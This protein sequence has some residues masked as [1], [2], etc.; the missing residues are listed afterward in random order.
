MRVL[1]DHQVFSLQAWGG[2]SRYFT[3]LMKYYE[4]G[5]K[6]QFE[7]PIYFSNNVHL[8]EVVSV[9]AKTFFNDYPFKGRNRIIFQVNQLVTRK[10]WRKKEFELFHPT[11]YNSDFL[12][13][14][15]SRP[16]ILT[17]HDMTY[18]IYPEL[19]PPGDPVPQHKKILIERASRIIA[20]SRHTK[21]DILR[22]YPVSPDKIEVIY[23]GNSLYKDQV[24][25]E[26]DPHLPLKFLLYVGNREGHKNFTRFIRA[27]TPLLQ[28]D[29]DLFLVCAGGG[30]LSKA[31]TTLITELGII[32]KVHHYPVNDLELIRLYSHARAFVFPSLYEGFGIPVLEAFGCNCPA[33]L[34]NSSSLPEIA[35]D[36]ALYFD[37]E[38]ENSI[39]EIV[40]HLIDNENLRK[41]LIE[42]GSERVREFSWKKTALK[43][44]TLYEK[45]LEE[46]N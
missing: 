46:A 42:R 45:V 12:N 2:I 9:S 3:E 7:L 38:D 11:Y 17:I 26:S 40:S 4:R 33:I 10:I 30:S 8:P 35:G 6:L 32:N 23:L 43:T 18:E 31:E 20:I 21:S 37:P 36:A 15:G 39:R 25:G 22:F 28:E 16:F 41:Q 1:Y 13:H 14:I 24:Y 29:R 27:I 19:F 5:D 44:A 34:S